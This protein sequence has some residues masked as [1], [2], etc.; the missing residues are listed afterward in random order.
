[1][2]AFRRA[3]QLGATFM[4]TELQLT[5]DSHLVAMHDSTIERTTNGRGT[6]R[7]YNLADLRQ[8]DAGS[9]FGPQFAGE[10][11][12]TLREILTF[13]LEADVVFYFEVKSG[14]M[15]GVEHALVN[16]LREARV[17]AHTAVLASDARVLDNVRQRDPTLISGLLFEQPLENPVGTAWQVGARQ[18][19]PQAGLVTREL[20]EKAHASG[21]Q[22]VT[23]T[24]NE[25]SEMRRVIAAGVDGVMTDYP[26]RLVAVLKES[27][28]RP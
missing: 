11:I 12:P 1:M 25:P 6:V 18:L 10:P 21:L 2:A 4:E 13:A 3:V 5:R 8:L 14:G 22:V 24:V 23:W 19:A 15:W 20:V 28:A 26:D 27:A 9:W 17:A 7:E 16:V